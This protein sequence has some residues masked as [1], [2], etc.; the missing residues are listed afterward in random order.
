ALCPI[1]FAEGRLLLD[2]DV[3]EVFDGLRDGVS[4]VC[5][6]DC[7]HSGTITR[8]AVGGPGGGARP[9]ERPR[10]VVADEAVVEAH[11]AFR[12]RLGPRA[13]PR[14]RSAPVMREIVFTACRAE[15]V[16]F[17]N[18]G[19]GDFTRHATV[20]L[21]GGIDAVTNGA[22]LDR[23]TAAFGANPRQHP[24]FAP[25]GAR[26]RALLRAFGPSRSLGPD[27]ATTGGAGVSPE[28][29]QLLES[30]ARLLSART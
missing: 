18:A 2:D 4:L 22:F 16:A 1:D 11:R 27:L 7:C 9:D 15:E 26:G 29:A 14:R 28:V 25:D 5:F 20:A 23:V 19:H 21:A 6:M 3:G 30:L 17:E 10:F 13:A 12:S 24:T 8:F